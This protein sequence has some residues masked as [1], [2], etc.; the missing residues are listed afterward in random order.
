M[1]I[2]TLSDSE[3]S[4]CPVHQFADSLLT[5]RITGILLRKHFRNTI[6]QG[7]NH[8]GMGIGVINFAAC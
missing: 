2:V 1:F 4:V 6:M 5:L 7:P 3:T 8:V